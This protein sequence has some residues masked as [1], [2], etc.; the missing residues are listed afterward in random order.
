MR[1]P[2]N[3]TKRRQPERR[4]AS[5]IPAGA[6]R[7][8]MP[9]FVEPSLAL[10]VD[11]PPSEPLWVHEIKFDGYRMQ[12]RVDGDDIRLLTRKAL[13]W[14]KR[15]PT[16]VAAL[17]ALDVDTALL[18]GEIVSEDEGGIPHFSDLQDDLKS[19]RRDR[20]RYHALD[21]LHLDGL[22]VTG[23]A[24]V[25]RKSLLQR[26]LGRAPTGLPLRYSEQ[27]N[28]NG[29]TMLKHACRMGLEGIQ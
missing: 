29:A 8:P 15:F 1:S 28:E 12:A 18:D 5:D 11:K 9:A 27:S 7:A 22:D 6:R 3:V 14:T 20:L 21:L 17:R 13:D 23:A 19:G 24:L 10:L 2:T 25:D 16:I 26:L 4:R